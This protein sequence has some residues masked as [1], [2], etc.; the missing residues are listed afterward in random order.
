M[1]GKSVCAR[2]ALA[3]A[4]AVM[5][6]GAA[7]HAGIMF[8][9]LSN[10]DVINDT[11][12]VTRGFEIELDGISPAEIAFTFGAPYIRYGNPVKIATATGTIVHYASAFGPSGW[13]VGTPAQDPLHPITT[14][15]HQLYF[16]GDPNYINEPGDHFGLAYNGNATKT[17]YRWLLGDASGNLTPAGANVPIP[18]P[19]WNVQPAAN[20]AVAPAAV[21]AVIPAP[22][23]EIPEN[24]FGEAIW[25]KVFV[26]E[27]AQPEQLDHLLVGNPGVPDGSK[28]GETEVEWQI[29]QT[30][31]GAG[32]ENVDSGLN[33]LQAGGKSI[34]RR[35]EFYKYTG[36]YSP[37]GEALD[38][39]PGPKG[40][41]V[42][43]FIGGQNAAINL[44]AFVIPEPGSLALLGIGVAA[45]AAGRRRGR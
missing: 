23:K 44:D 14:G 8:G 7:A 29:L 40:E 38:E 12:Q 27:A 32:F 1:S 35:Y 25:A 30:G 18:V 34:T 45:L 2:W 41:F 4:F 13:A 15:G 22:P 6:F 9:S 11:G 21:Q 43:A 3:G 42:G 36:S 10:M 39:T 37:E 16:Q 5:S 33:D 26:T 24:L 28:P 20:P 19:T 17:V 31:K